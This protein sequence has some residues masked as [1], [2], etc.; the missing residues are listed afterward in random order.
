MSFMIKF[1]LL[2]SFLFDSSAL[3][4][5][6]S[7]DR[8]VSHIFS[9]T[10]FGSVSLDREHL[11]AEEMVSDDL[12]ASHLADRCLAEAKRLFKSNANWKPVEVL[13]KN[14][15]VET[16]PLD[17][18]YANSG[19]HL[20]R[21]TGII[22]ASA[23]K[24]FKFQISREGFQSIDEYLVNHRN[25]DNFKWVTRPEFAHVQVPP[26]REPFPDDSPYQ[27]MLNRV[28]WKYPIKRRE[29][30]ALDVVHNADRI[31]I[32]KSSLSP[33]RPGG[34][35]YQNL[36]PKDERTPYIDPVDPVPR[37][38]VRAVQYYA[39]HVE[40]IDDN[41]CKLTMVTWG[42]MCDSYSAWWVNLFN[43]HVFIT[44]KFDRFIRVMGGESLFEESKIM[45][46]A[47]RLLKIIPNLKPDTVA[48]AS[49][50][51]VA[52]KKIV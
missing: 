26:A 10:T 34:S 18:G 4:I 32:S 25:V 36:V 19:V 14:I 2:S 42:E 48:A 41:S 9:S 27:L 39:S 31:L 51:F 30:V 43:A 35:R 22:P 46:N 12:S 16:I 7:R 13:D 29:F 8:R 37:S 47:W 38:L 15:K 6:L 17:G 24:F 23:E 28:E 49:S 20:V 11:I 52:G 33:L 40:P 45:D 21:G 50:D 5:A 44:P 1:L 3:K